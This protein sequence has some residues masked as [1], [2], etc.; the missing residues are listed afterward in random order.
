MVI[1]RALAVPCNT[2]TSSTCHKSYFGLK[3]WRSKRI[4]PVTLHLSI[5]M[6]VCIYVWKVCV[7]R[8]AWNHHTVQCWDIILSHSF[9]HFPPALLPLL[10]SWSPWKLTPRS[11]VPVAS[12]KYHHFV[13]FFILCCDLKGSWD[14]KK[15]SLRKDHSFKMVVC[16][17]VKCGHFNTPNASM[18][19]HLALL[20]TEFYTAYLN[21]LYT[22]EQKL[23]T[24]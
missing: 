13:F 22:Q 24:C 19:Q 8:S 1:S 12:T 16:D 11:S 3:L 20:F 15:R 9:S 7:R 6:S 17:H 14:V 21:T 18:L 4:N 5:G 23:Y 2:E 10:T